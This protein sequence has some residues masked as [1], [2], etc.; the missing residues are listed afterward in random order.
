MQRRTARAGRKGSETSS[1]RRA[2]RS[3]ELGEAVG[4]GACSTPLGPDRAVGAE[5]ASS[6]VQTD[7]TGPRVVRAHRKRTAGDAPHSERERER[8]KKGPASPQPRGL[9]C[10]LESK[11]AQ[12]RM[13]KAGPMENV[14]YIGLDVHKETIVIAVA[15]SD[16]SQPEVLC[17]IPNETQRLLKQMSKLGAP[18]LLRVCYEAGPTGFGVYRALQE[19]GIDCKVVAPSLIPKKSGDRVKTDKRDA[20]KLARFLRSGDLTAIHVPD[21][22][23]EAMRDLVRSREDAKEAERAARHQLTK[24]LLRHGRHFTGKTTWTEA[25]LDWIRSQQFKH[26]AQNRVLVDYVRTVENA[27]TRVALLMKDIV[28]LVETWSKKPLVQALQALRGVQLI[29]A[30]AIAA[31]IDDF[32]RFARPSEF[33]AYLGLVPSENSS[34]ETKRRGGITRAGNRHVRTLLVESAWG[35]RHNARMSREIRKRNEGLSEEVKQIAWKAQCRLH[36]RYQHMVARGKAHQVAITAVARELAGF[37]WS[38]ARQPTL[39]AVK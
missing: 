24:F 32:S 23:T 5:A 10:Q 39:L 16:G 6:E 27:T 7:A 3:L 30:V 12:S 34:G 28:D 37:I 18:G 36:G 11:S 13:R 8:T 9:R 38:I 21:E 20:V 26:E 33:M 35:Y 22:A 1:V 31:E 4:G 25:H 14:R 15:E 29:T 17:T 2:A 19:A